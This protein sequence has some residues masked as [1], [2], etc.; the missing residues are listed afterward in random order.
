M[1]EQYHLPKCYNPLLLKNIVW[2]FYFSTIHLFQ[3]FMHLRKAGT[4]LL[5]APFR[6]FVGYSSFTHP[7]L[8]SF[9]NRAYLYNT[10]LFSFN[11][12]CFQ[13]AFLFFISS[14]LTFK[15]ILFFVIS[16]SITSS[17]CTNPI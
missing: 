2:S 13:L 8:A 17:S 6:G 4:V 16:I 7:S 9:T 5:Q 12:G 15:V 10:P 11:S 14:S 3:N 1:T